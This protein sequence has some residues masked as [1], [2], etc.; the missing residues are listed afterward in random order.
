M[1]IRSHIALAAIS[2]ILSVLCG[3]GGSSTVDRSLEPATLTPSS[4]LERQLLKHLADEPA[5]GELTID[6]AVIALGPIYAAASA[7]RCRT[8]RLP[9]QSAARLACQAGQGW[10][11]APP[12]ATAGGAGGAG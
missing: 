10:F 9:G 5:P 11:Y 8:V 2:F 6:G 1:R 4:D 3:C 7:A 12:L